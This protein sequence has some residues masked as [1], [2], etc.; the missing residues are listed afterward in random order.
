M[1]EQELT[2]HKTI[3]LLNPY[4]PIPSEGWREYR[5]TLLGKMLAS[6]GWRVTWWTANFSHHFKKCRTQGWTNLPVSEGFVIKLVPTP[7]YMHNIGLGRLWFELVYAWRVWVAAQSLESPSII[8]A[9]DPPQQVGFLATAL[10]QRLKIPII[11]DVMDL[12]PEL[13]QM[14][15]PKGLKRFSTLI[16]WPF[17]ALRRHNLRSAIGIASLCRQYLSVA[18]SQASGASEKTGTVIYNGIDVS[19]FRR[20]T[21]LSSSYVKPPGAVWIIYAGSLGDNYDIDT[22]LK[23]VELLAEGRGGAEHIKVF[24][25]GDGP[26]RS[27][28]ETC[29]RMFGPK[30]FEYLGV[31]SHAEL[32]GLYQV[33]DIGLCL[34]GPES[35]VGMPDK[36]YDYTAAGLPVINSLPGEV[37][38]LIKRQDFG[39]SY[40][41]GSSSSLLAAILKLSC[42]SALRAKMAINA[43]KSGDSFD[44]RVQYAEF[45]SLIEDSLHASL[46]K[47]MP[48]R[49]KQ[50]D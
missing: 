26:K 25:A 14:A 41:A 27:A 5:Y 34:Y 24:V 17:Y 12:W 30:R 50:G 22:V 44:A 16:F 2:G 31:L 19:L 13:F 7:K 10:G 40:V 38:D 45:V 4:G 3:W 48:E 18:T 37:A 29:S 43:Y 42:D 39:V 47:G 11:L 49:S 1:V 33:C 28:V 6:K 46:I 9:T 32:A 15:L 36:I 8:V 23:V 20:Q 21:E 35:N